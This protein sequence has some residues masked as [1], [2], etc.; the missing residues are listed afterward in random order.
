MAGAPA[1]NCALM[2]APIAE[3]SPDQDALGAFETLTTLSATSTLTM[4]AMAKSC[5]ASGDPL[6][7]S[8]LSKK[9]GPP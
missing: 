8:S 3:R 5:S 6:A 1:S 9:K 2:T 4:P 7:Q